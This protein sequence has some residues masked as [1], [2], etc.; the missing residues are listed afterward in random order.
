M[1]NRESSVPIKTKEEIRKELEEINKK[2][3]DGYKEGMGLEENNSLKEQRAQLL[4]LLG[5]FKYEDFGSEMGKGSEKEES[6]QDFKEQKEKD[7]LKESEDKFMNAFQELGTFNQ[8]IPN[9]YKEQSENLGKIIDELK[10][11]NIDKE[12]IDL[13]EKAVI[14]DRKDMVNTMCRKENIDIYYKNSGKD[15]GKHEKINIAM[16]IEHI[17]KSDIEMDKIKEQL[18]KI[19]KEIT[20]AIGE[21]EISLFAANW[22]NA[23]SFLEKAEKTKNIKE[24]QVN[25]ALTMH[26]LESIEKA[27]DDEGIKKALKPMFSY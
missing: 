25:L 11:G 22:A 1:E 7:P 3:D 2:I 26:I 10:K 20:K 8:T 16:Y 24:Q 6:G 4:N 5:E 17:K 21:F 23:R 15:E 18:G 9:W 27:M 14:E 12:T 19:D 13:L